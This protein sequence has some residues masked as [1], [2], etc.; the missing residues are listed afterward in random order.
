MK[1]GLELYRE[2]LTPE[3]LRFARHAGET[4]IIAPLINCFRSAGPTLA[5]GDDVRGWGD[6]STDTLWTRAELQGLV[7][8]VR[9][10][11]FSSVI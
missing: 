7:G 11:L 10:E 1:I 6:C 4:H 5:A 9:Q 8:L 3:N 2:Q